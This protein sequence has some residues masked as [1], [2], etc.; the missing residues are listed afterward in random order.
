MVG[1][2]WVRIE[3]GSFL[4][5]STTDENSDD[6]RPSFCGVRTNRYMYVKWSENRKAELYDY[7]KDPLELRSVASSD[8]YQDV[9]RRM[10]RA[11]VNL[12]Y[13]RPRGFHWS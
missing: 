10:H 1:R 13:P 12:C 4:K 7:R 8:R 3:N 9:R 5:G 6:S 2:S 11:A